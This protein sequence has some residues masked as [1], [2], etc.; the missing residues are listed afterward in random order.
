MNLSGISSSLGV[1]SLILLF[2]GGAAFLLTREV[3]FFV[4][5]NL[6]L[7][8][9][10]LISYLS[11]GRE[12][13][14]AFLG[15]R[16]TKYG[17]NAALYSAL[18]VGV[19]AMGNFLSAR[20]STRIDTTEAKVF[21]LSPQSAKIVRE[22]P[23]EVEMIAFVEGG[24]DPVLEDLFKTY[25]H[26]SSKIK[27][28]MVDPDKSPDLA[29]K[30]KISTYNTVRVAYGEQST[31]V[32]KPDEEALTNAVVKVTQSTKKTLCV[33]EGHGEP[34]IDDLE[35][36]R[37]YGALKTALESE[38]YTVQKTLL[39]TQ[40]K[41]PAD[42]NLLI[43]PAPQK[44]YLEPE[45]ALVKSYLQG[46]GRAM[47]LF[48]AQHGPDLLP[49]VADYGIHVGEDVVVDQVVRL[50]QGPALGLDPIVNSYGVHPI[51]E[52]FAQR[53]IFPLT[54][55]VEPATDKKKGIEVTTIAKTSASSWAE[56]DLDSVFQKGQVSLDPSRDKKGPVSIA[57]AAKVNLKEAGSEPEGESRLVAFGSDQFTNNKNINN[58]YNRDLMMNAVGW[59]VGEEK[60]IS[61][62][63]R[64]LRASR[65]QLT[66]D[67]V[68]RI[69]YLSV[70]VLPEVLL[71]AGI[72]VWARRRNA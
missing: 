36:P 35:S 68:Q 42:C 69:F 1:F 58:F 19:V 8:L 37:G 48:A 5:L 26:E 16:S 56:S 71:L 21:S 28:E 24:K 29:E 38:N 14:R 30:Y 45:V 39:A 3:S 12:S 27:F 53:T 46:G 40:E 60:L 62:R 64:N 6:A 20:H 2:F 50:F 70:L 44:P 43:A 57:V 13:L 72:A 31:L 52:G 25:A 18:I 34:D 11:S 22:L 55:S 66:Q 15:E 9:F 47:F 65:V 41:P 33:V 59:T 4:V 10:A 51:T 32:N 61:I 54:R 67:E 7:G 23:G 63:A 17:A 49:L